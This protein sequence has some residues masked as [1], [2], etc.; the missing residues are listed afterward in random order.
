MGIPEHFS[1]ILLGKGI[2]FSSILLSSAHICSAS[3]KLIN[4]AVQMDDKKKSKN[5]LIMNG[6]MMFVSGTIF[7]YYGYYFLS[8]NHS[9][10]NKFI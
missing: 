8:K 2:I 5:L 1:I 4:S 10:I 3:L 6:L 7:S 9:H